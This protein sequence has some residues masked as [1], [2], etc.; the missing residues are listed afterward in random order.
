MLLD[1]DE[2]LTAPDHARPR[3]KRTSKWWER[4]SLSLSVALRLFSQRGA[5]VIRVHWRVYGANSIDDN[6]TCATL[7]TFRMP[8]THLC[9]QHRTF[10]TLFRARP[11]LVPWTSMPI[12]LPH[13][14]VEHTAH[15]FSANGTNISSCVLQNSSHEMNSPCSIHAMPPPAHGQELL[16]LRHYVTRSRS[17]WT[18]KMRLYTA[19]KP[20]TAAVPNSRYTAR[21]GTMCDEKRYSPEWANRTFSILNARWAPGWPN[22]QFKLRVN[23][24]CGAHWMIQ[25]TPDLAERRGERDPRHGR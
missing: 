25:P 21:V 6:P 7:P 3:G 16:V 15:T 11:G 1:L 4:P 8:A 5:D 20:C 19:M 12:K 9:Y 24:R 17:E 2:F 14:Q 10:K 22:H 18:R 13:Q 23:N